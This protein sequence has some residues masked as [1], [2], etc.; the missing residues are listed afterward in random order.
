MLVRYVLAL[1]QPARVSERNR[2]RGIRFRCGG[3]LT[4]LRTG[5]GDWPVASLIGWTM[6]RSRD[7][8][9]GAESRFSAA[10]RGLTPMGCTPVDIG[11]SPLV[12]EISVGTYTRLTF[13][14]AN[15]L[16]SGG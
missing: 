16:G 7:S 1:G 5:V 15:G 8:V 12:W 11:M 14:I 3:A 13:A 2:G 9:H 10:P 6:F 4:P